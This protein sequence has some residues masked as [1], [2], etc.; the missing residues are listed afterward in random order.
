M[1]QKIR[2]TFSPPKKSLPIYIDSIGYNPFELDFNRPEG[3]PYYHWLQTVKGEGMIEIMGRKFNLEKGHGIL[4]APYTS[5]SYQP[6]Y[7]KTRDWSTVYLTFSGDAI[8]SIFNALEINHSVIYRETSEEHLYNHIQLT[9]SYLESKHE[10]DPNIY[11]D[12]STKLYDFIILLIR[13][14]KIDEQIPRIHSYDKV[15]PIVEWLEQVFPKDIGL[16]EISQQAN[17]SPQHLNKLFHDTFNMS[18]YAFLVQLRIREAKRLLLTNVDLTLKE[19]A[20]RVGFNSVSHFVATF[21]SREG[22][23]PKQYREKYG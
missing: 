16:L 17:L 13:Y 7:E 23:T 6:N 20:S 14:A 1:D 8:E 12:L 11:Y 4:L 22:M 3:F 9:L 15:K 2:Y 5:H 19:I 21:K 18:T 10:V